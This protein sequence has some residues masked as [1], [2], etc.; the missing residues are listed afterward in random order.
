MRKMSQE[1]LKKKNFIGGVLL[2]WLFVLLCYLHSLS[3]V[4]SKI[5]ILMSIKPCNTIADMG[6]LGGPLLL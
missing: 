3:N 4:S 1:H 2:S 6:R 5:C